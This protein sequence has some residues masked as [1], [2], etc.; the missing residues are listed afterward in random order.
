VEKLQKAGFINIT[1]GLES[2]NSEILRKAH[3]KASPQELEQVLHLF[4]KT[5][6]NIRVL[7][8]V[9]LP[10][11][12]WKTI[13]AT[14]LFIQKLQ[15]I[16][17]LYYIPT[18]FGIAK[19][20]PGTELCIKMKKAGRLS[21]KQWLET[22]S[23][24]FYTV[25]NSSYVLKKMHHELL[26]YISYEYIFTIKGFFRQLRIVLGSKNRFKILWLAIKKGLAKTKRV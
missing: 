20:Y 8:T 21:D 16:K 25:E 18:L 2:A 15:R 26:S 17:Y 5:P 3:R 4:S 7:L 6:I 9:G 24:I 14:A 13:K 1:F 19:V 10:G 22:E 23:D 12:T 11:E